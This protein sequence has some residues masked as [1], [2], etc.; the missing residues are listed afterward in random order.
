ML[1]ET[2]L[3]GFDSGEGTGGGESESVRFREGE[4]VVVCECE[5]RVSE[6]DGEGATRVGFS[7][8]VGGIDSAIPMRRR[9]GR[10]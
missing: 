8:G 7:V 4:W 9:R 10:E 6:R 5:W 2:G 1:K 3:V